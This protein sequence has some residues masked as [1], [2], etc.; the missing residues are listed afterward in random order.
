MKKSTKALTLT[1]AALLIA[2]GIGGGVYAVLAEKAAAETDTAAETEL[3]HDNVEYVYDE[4]GDLK[5]EIFYD[6]D[7]YM[8]RKDYFNS[9]GV[10]YVTEFDKDDNEIFSSMTETNIVGSITK[11]TSYEN[12]TLKETVE[13]VYGDDLRTLQ[14]KTVK[15]YT[16]E[17]EYAEKIYYNEEGKA[18]RVCKYLN[19]ELTEEIIYDEDYQG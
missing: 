15:T 4:N 2:G 13:Y 17:D 18:A 19:G 8:G 6:N 5:S 14:K 10:S 3:V 7:V 12:H 11:T 1:V 16:G 9:D